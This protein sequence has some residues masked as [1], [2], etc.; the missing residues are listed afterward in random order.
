MG[1]HGTGTQRLTNSTSDRNQEAEALTKK[2]SIKEEVLPIHSAS[3]SPSGGIFEPSDGM[4][5]DTKCKENSLTSS[6]AWTTPPDTELR[7]K[8]HGRHALRWDS[9]R[10][11]LP[12]FGLTS[13]SPSPGPWRPASGSRLLCPFLRSPSPPPPLILSHFAHTPLL[14][15]V[16]LHSLAVL[17]DTHVY[18]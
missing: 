13:G 18:M 17:W 1:S 5:P 11:H 10:P 3:E 4:L 2:A 6:T 8:Q 16:L 9:C 15:W 7:D 12:D 14:R